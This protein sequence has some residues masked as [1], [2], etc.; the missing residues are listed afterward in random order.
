AKD[1]TSVDWSALARVGGTIVLYMGV[2]T[3][4]RI[5]AALTAAGMPPDT[6]AA[7]IQWGTYPTQ[8][9]VT[10]T[11]DTLADEI[12]RQEL[13]APVITVIGAVAALRE[14]IAWFDNRPL[15]G[16]RIVVTRAR[17]QAAT[18]SERLM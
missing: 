7:A 14:Q 10:A 15:F 8:R 12:R 4:P 17:S 11:V 5:A 16:K 13:A 6:P 9:T 2:K 18:L 1:T 3:L